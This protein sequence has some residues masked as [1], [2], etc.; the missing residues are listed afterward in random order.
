MVIQQLSALI[1]SVVSLLIIA[2]SNP[3]SIQSLRQKAYNGSNLKI[4]KNLPKGQNYEQSIVS[5]K[6]EGLKIY[7]L[8]T[9][10]KGTPP[11]GGWPVIIFNHGYITPEEYQTGQYYASYIDAFARNEFMVLEPDYRGHGSSQG[12]PSMAIYSPDYT[13]D[14]LNAI[15]SIKKFKKAN[16]KKI[17]MWGHSMGGT[18]TFRALVISKDIKAADIWAGVIGN[19][20]DLIAFRH[21]QERE[22]LL[23]EKTKQQLFDKYG[24]LS[25]N[26]KFWASIDPITYIKD[27]SIPIQLQHSVSDNQ[28]PYTLSQKLFDT[29]QRNGKK[30]VL[31]SY[32]NDDHNLS[33][34]L[35]TALARSVAFFKINLK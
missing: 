28:V 14:V 1:I 33:N 35:D 30:T 16:P 12:K 10:P 4:E 17:G 15:G 27:I 20:Q 5:Y 13:I 25:K 21:P 9:V 29:L 7:A 26:P 3:T 18:V 23:A 6:S 24:N 8:L 22:Q 32:Q 34:N 11:A 19:F 31:Y 2:T